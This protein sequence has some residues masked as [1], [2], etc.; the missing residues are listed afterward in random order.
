MEYLGVHAHG[1]SDRLGA[2]GHVCLH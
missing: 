2:D 1:L